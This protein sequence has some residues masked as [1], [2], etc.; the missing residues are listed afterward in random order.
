MVSLCPLHTLGPLV[1]EA[2]LF[3]LFD[4]YS[5]FLKL[6]FCALFLN[7]GISRGMP[8]GRLPQSITTHSLLLGRLL[9][10]IIGHGLLLG[11]LPKAI[12]S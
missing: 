8:H 11:R 7:F 9:Q 5:A 6:C 2:S 1:S 10:T 4:S 12:I 3:L